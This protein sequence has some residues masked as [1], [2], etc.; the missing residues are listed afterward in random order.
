MN[1]HIHVLKHTFPQNSLALL[2]FALLAEKK[3]HSKKK[4][5]ST[6]YILIECISYLSV[7]LV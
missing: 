5:F 6:P 7:L 4:F 2:C 1:A 3:N